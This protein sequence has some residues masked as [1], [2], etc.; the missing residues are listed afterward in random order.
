MLI[1]FVS[2]S[3]F[4][5]F[6][7]YGTRLS[8]RK[9]A[10][11]CKCAPDPSYSDL[12]LRAACIAPGGLVVGYGSQTM[13]VGRESQRQARSTPASTKVGSAARSSYYPGPPSA[14]SV[15]IYEALFTRPDAIPNRDRPKAMSAHSGIG[16]SVAAE[17][18]GPYRDCTPAMS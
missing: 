7:I 12:P 18:G 13:A 8:T 6:V 10:G 11:S 4:I 16:P 2:R 14:R 15:R 1:P 5:Q 3:P 17:A 9:H